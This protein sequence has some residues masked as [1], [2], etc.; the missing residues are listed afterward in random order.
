MH[1]QLA[2]RH[3]SDYA[4]R[5][6]AAASRDAAWCN[7]YAEDVMCHASPVPKPVGGTLVERAKHMKNSVVG[8]GF[9][10]D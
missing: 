2:W 6:A 8:S 5:A 4:K 7:D 10:N 9:A 1:Q 3:V